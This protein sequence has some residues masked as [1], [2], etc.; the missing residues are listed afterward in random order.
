MGFKHL[1]SSYLRAYKAPSTIVENIR[2]ISSFYNKQTQFTK[3]PNERKL[4]YNNELHNY[5]Q[6]DK[7]QKQ[8]QFKPN[9]NPNKAN[10]GPISRVFNA[11]QTQFYLLLQKERTDVRCRMSEITCLWQLK[12]NTDF[13]IIIKLNT[14]IF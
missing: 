10:F 11:K 13:D 4:I 6:S 5:Y 12:F 1:E 2:Q 3:C 8:S 14:W 7:S 9:S